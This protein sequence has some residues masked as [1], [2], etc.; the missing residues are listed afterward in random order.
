LVTKLSRFADGVMEF[1][2]LS[3]IITI[4]LFFN[5]YSSRI[6]EPDKLT[7]LRS[8]ALIVLVAWITK[9]VEQS[10]RQSNPRIDIVDWLKQI[11]RSPLI[12]P[13]VCLFFVYLLATVLSVTPRVSLLGSYQ[14]LQGTYTTFSYMVIF[15]AIAGNMRKS[16]QVERL[17]TVVILSSLPVSL[18]GVLQKYRIDPVPW[19]G[20]VSIRI[21]ANMGNSIFVAAYLIMANPFT[22][23]RIYR[24]F[25]AILI[26]ET[27]LLIHMAKSTAYVFIGSLQMIAIYFTGSRGPWLGWMA[28]A[29]S[30]FVLLSLYWK[31]RLL[32]FGFLGFGLLL[33][34][35]LIIFN[36]PGGPLEGLR[37]NPQIGRL[38]HLLEAE[39]G[40]GRV[41]VL[42]WQGASQL[43]APHPPLEYPDGK[44]DSFNLIRPVVGYGPESMYVAFN[45]FYPPEL[46]NLERRN[47]SPDR[48]HNET[49][50]TLVTTGAL[51]LIVYL[52][53]FGFLFYYG[54]RWLGLITNSLHRNL[55][56]ILY[57]LGGLLGAIGLCFWREVAYLGIGLP[58]GMIVGVIVFLVIVALMGHYQIPKTT[59][60]AMRALT[61]MGLMST[62]V[63]HFIEINLG[64][65]I[66]ATRTYFWV[67]LGILV[68]TGYFLPMQSDYMEVTGEE[69]RKNNIDNSFRKVEKSGQKR[70]RKTTR[71]R[72]KQTRS[73]GPDWAIEA[74]VSGVIIAIALT[75]LGYDFISGSQGGGSAGAILWNSL[76]RLKSVNSGVSY[77]VLAMML[78]TWLVAGVLMASEDEGNSNVSI[79]GKKIFVVYGFSLLLGLIFW[80]WH[81]AN[82]ASI[83]SIQAKSLA[84]ILIHVHRYE[85]LLTRYYIFLFGL[86]LVGA[87]CITRKIPFS[88]DQ[89]W[90]GL[91]AAFASIVVAFFIISNSNLRVIQADIAFKLA[92]PFTRGN[93]W[94]VAIEIYKHSLKLAPSEDYY[95]LFLGRA[96]LE[97]AKTI[98]DPVERDNLIAQAA[99]DLK[100]AQKI[101]PLNTDHTANL[102]RLH[103]LWAGFTTD[104]SARQQKGLISKDYFSGAV[105]LSPNNARLW[106]EWALLYLN[107]LNQPDDAVK[108]L[109][110]SVELDPNYEWTHALLG[111]YYIQKGQ[112]VENADEKTIAFDKALYHFGEAKRLSGD[113]SA[114]TNYSLAQAQIYINTNQ[115]KYAISTLEEALS[116]APN[117]ND[118]WRIEQ[119]LAQLYAKEG[120]KN[121]A[122]IHAN[123]ALAFS[124]EDQKQAIQSFI[125]QIQSMP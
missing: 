21:A 89:S 25:R 34:V 87:Y 31:K 46:G 77:G 69:L 74:L 106:D 110:H 95:Y 71:T 44:K 62:F 121:N 124:P 24:S 73:F 112:S 75:T 66:A 104:S 12:L 32:L 15:F 43:V 54:L 88:F 91:V 60:E 14:R 63:A 120:D 42:I 29:F 90:A 70:K 78:T 115:Q 28:G 19:A 67:F 100:L 96:Y 65:A 52:T 11:S 55:F 3:S 57:L 93:S 53:L 18:Y 13:V 108:L 1:G 49:W 98:N 33:A 41:R 97:H 123:Q 102:A 8:I 84:E 114:Q 85:D 117:T 2:W 23:I 80:L 56:I 103:S 83:L 64:I 116:L 48:S 72:I 101:N 26:E 36:I 20:D 10:I 37:T 27:G 17:I 119:T 79:W 51:G 4:P 58:L 113:K 94:P 82:L 39:G 9:L 61:I 40:T 35:F 81:S 45:R 125:V 86:I 38:G 50:D 5:V 105:S 109:D 107:I 122:L 47:A 99:S 30:L 118:L 16:E 92:E 111:E 6:F 59:E 76:V 7:L 68:V 22:L